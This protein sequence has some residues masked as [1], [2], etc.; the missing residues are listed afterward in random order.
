MELFVKWLGQ[1]GFELTDGQTSI[2]IDPYLSDMVER[3]DKV[4]RMVPSPIRPEEAHPDLY[5]I[6]HDHM[7][8]LDSDTISVMNKDQVRFAA[9]ESCMAKLIE[10]G[11]SERSITKLDRGGILFFG[12]FTIKAVYAKHTRDSIGLVVEKDGLTVYFTGDSEY[13]GEVGKDLSCDIL[14]VCINGRWGNMG[15]PEA[16]QLAERVNARLAIPNHYGLFAENTADPEPFLKG[17]ASA[18]RKGYRMNHGE[19]FDLA[20]LL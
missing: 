20:E 9:P 11:I 18:G 2:L 13:D 17:L 10:L 19:S 15:I 4:K 5:L 14:F 16:L 3:F 8:H 6:T 1:G 12:D 7:D